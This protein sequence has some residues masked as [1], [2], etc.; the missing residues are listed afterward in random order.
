M[1]LKVIAWGNDHTRTYLEL[2][3]RG[4]SKMLVEFRDSSA[5]EFARPS[6]IGFEDSADV[7]EHET[8]PLK[9]RLPHPTW[10]HPLR[11]CIIPSGDALAPPFKGSLVKKGRNPL[12]KEISMAWGKPKNENSITPTWSKD[13][14]CIQKLAPPPPGEEIYPYLKAVYR[15]ARKLEPTDESKKKEFNKIANG[16]HRKIKWNR[17]RLIVELTALPHMK[18]KMKWKY[19]RALQYARQRGVKSADLIA[20]MKKKGGINGCVDKYIPSK[21]P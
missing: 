20:F 19:T 1:K 11:G 13:L 9:G 8:C 18:P 16:F 21:K 6:E 10:H 2:H 5:R 3:A 15:Y 7:F 12:K 14:K 4:P 17:I